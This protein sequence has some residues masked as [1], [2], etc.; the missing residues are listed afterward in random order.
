LT[1]LTPADQLAT[2]RS[3]LASI[4][5]QAGELSGKRRAALVSGGTN[6][7]I[8]KLDAEIEKLRAL[9]QIERD[10]I[11]GLTE[12]IRKQEVA[13]VIK[14]KDEQI[15]RLS[16]ELD[17]S[18]ED[19]REIQAMVGELVSRLRHMCKARSGVL[20]MFRSAD[21]EVEA[22]ANN[23]DGA[24]L[25][26]SS[27]VTLVA[28]EFFRQGRVAALPG[29]SAVE[30]TWPAPICPR[31]E[32]ISTPERIT[33]F[34]DRI[35]QANRYAVSLMRDGRAPALLAQP[36][37]DARTSAQ[38]QLGELLKRQ[39]ELAQ[40][41]SKESEYLQTMQQVAVLQDRVEA[42]R[43]A[44]TKEVVATE[45]AER[46]QG[47]SAQKRLAELQQKSAGLV[48]GGLA[49]TVEYFKLCREIAPL[50]AEVAA[51]QAATGAPA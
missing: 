9:G 42:E 34:S 45:A 22:A 10:R 27:V 31:I 6:A 44:V 5:A 36:G 32:W 11:E 35:A 13:E 26:P 41:P 19:A 33:P 30:P 51:E 47:S 49:H 40:D 15:E 24:A 39:M 28:N 1:K 12:T 8:G 17:L 16:K 38:V 50:A 4:E 43:A 7:E 21:P 46:P 48:I 3:A 25:T 14:R 2:S 23:P 29:V 37:E 18:A 20:P